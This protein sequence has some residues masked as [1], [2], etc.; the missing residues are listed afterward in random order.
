MSL[1]SHHHLS[2]GTGMYE[3][4]LDWAR[5]TAAV[6]YD[7]LSSLVSRQSTDPRV[8][9]RIMSVWL[10]VL[11][12]LSV[13][14]SFRQSPPLIFC[15][16]RLSHY[17][18]P[19]IAHHPPTITLCSLPITHRLPLVSHHLSPVHSSHPFPSLH[20]VRCHP[21]HHRVPSGG[22]R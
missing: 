20:S 21:S 14:L 12:A 1:F 10:S 19:S 5:L 4:S 16:Q 7:V 2:V 15:L 18:F 17:C 11:S 3:I 9:V 8:V 22:R 6:S 13:C